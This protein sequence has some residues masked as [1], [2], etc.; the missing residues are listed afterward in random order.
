MGNEKDFKETEFIKS[1]LS[2]CWEI[3]TSETLAEPK[4]ARIQESLRW[5]DIV[6]QSNVPHGKLNR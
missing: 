1:Q 6:L 5:L 2:S 3:L 4:Y